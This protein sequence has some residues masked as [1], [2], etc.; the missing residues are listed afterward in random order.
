MLILAWPRLSRT[1]L[2]SAFS[3]RWEPAVWR[4]QWVDACSRWAAAASNSSPRW[5]SRVALSRTTV[6]TISLDRAA[7]HGFG[8]ADD[9]N[10]EGHGLPFLRQ[11]AKADRPA[12]ANQ[13][14]H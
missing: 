3:L 8:G 4:I 13:F 5:R 14:G 9:Q 10:Y 11:R 6:L 1:T 12:V 7:R 2:I